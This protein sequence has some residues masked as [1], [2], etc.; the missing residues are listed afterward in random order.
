MIAGLVHERLATAQ[1]EIVSVSR[2]ATI[3]VVRIKITDVGRM[4]L[5]G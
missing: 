1:R 2:R 3:E 5:E 4:A